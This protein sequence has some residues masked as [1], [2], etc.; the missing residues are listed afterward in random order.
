MGVVVVAAFVVILLILFTASIWSAVK[1][2]VERQVPR[3]LQKV[4]DEILTGAQPSLGTAKYAFPATV[5]HASRELKAALVPQGGIPEPLLWEL[6]NAIGE[7]CRQNGYPEGLK[8]GARPD[9]KIRIDISLADLLQMSWLAHLGF[10]HMM[11]NYR[12][13]EVHRF[14]GEEDAREAARTVTLLE[15]AIPK[16]HRPFADVKAQALARDKMISGWW[17]AMPALR[18]AS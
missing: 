16:A 7:S 17:V 1:F 14:I 9:D 4:I 5:L 8:L 13:I 12:G 10:Q 3:Q 2:Y 11:P 6:G 18:S 15:C